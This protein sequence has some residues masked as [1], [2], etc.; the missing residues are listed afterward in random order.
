[1]L[2]GN[3]GPLLARRVPRGSAMPWGGVDI[4]AVRRRVPDIASANTGSFHHRSQCGLSRYRSSLVGI[5]EPIGRAAGGYQTGGLLYG[6]QIRLY[7]LS[8]HSKGTD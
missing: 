7:T 2:R 8:L 1:M 3:R 4:G 5:V 6:L